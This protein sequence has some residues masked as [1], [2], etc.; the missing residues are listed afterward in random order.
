M[1]SKVKSLSRVLGAIAVWYFLAFP[2]S[3]GGSFTQVG[4]FAS[5]NACENYRTQ[6]SAQSAALPCWSD[7]AK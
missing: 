7:K 1:A 2:A 4:P 3:G 5:Q 6:V